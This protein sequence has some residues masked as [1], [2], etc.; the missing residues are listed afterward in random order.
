[1]RE[2]FNKSV[3]GSLPDSVWDGEMPD[4]GRRGRRN[5]SRT[6]TRNASR[7]ITRVA[8]ALSLPLAVSTI[9]L[10]VLN[11]RQ[12]D[13]IA[14]APQEIIYRV[15][16][17]VRGEVVLPDSTLVKLNSGSILKVPANFGVDSRTVQLDGEAYFDVHPDRSCPFFIKTPQDITV[18]VTGTRFNVQCFSDSPKFDLTLIQGAVEISKPDRELIR[19]FP[20]E[21]IVINRDFHNVAPVE[22]P[23]RALAWTEGVLRFDH[24]PMSETLAQIERWYGVRFNVTDPSLLNSSFTAEFRSE[25]LEEVL[26]LLCYSSKFSYS[27]D[28]TTINLKLDK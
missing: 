25:T 28:G 9:L 6:V 11:G 13:E 26:R 14:A 5:A 23:A 2:K 7:V 10:A 4:L 27:I 19:V 12:T 20:S 24:T 16:N 3:F 18:K 17:T 1:M 15:N 8:A 21:H 22:E